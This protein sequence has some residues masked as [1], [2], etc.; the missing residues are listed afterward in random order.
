MTEEFV[1]VFLN[2]LDRLS[3]AF[4]THLQIAFTAV[5]FGAMIA[6]PLGI[7]LA[8]MPRSGKKIIAVLSIFQ[9]VPSMVMFGLL[10]PLS[11]LGRTTAVIVLT[12]YSLLPILRNTYTGISEVSQGYLEAA[13]GMGMNN[14][15]ILFQVEVPI[16]LPVIVAG[17]RLSSVYV[18]SWTTLAAIVGAGGLGDIIIIGLFQNN[19]P[20]LL[21]G[22]I[23]TSILAIV[24][25]YVTGKIARA[26][27]PRGL[28]KN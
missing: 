18:I 21:L 10:L 19:R 9:T 16:S 4:F 27:T 25:S 3:N 22:A 17:I 14:R 6:V 28:R 7:L 12:L 8:R 11:G 1:A 24:T 15:Q 2:N 26:V 20:L 5:A 23:S 13:R